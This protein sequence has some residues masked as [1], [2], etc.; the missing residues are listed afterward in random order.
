MQGQDNGAVQDSGNVERIRDILFGS[1]MRDYD[2][3]FQ[4]LDERLSREAGELRSEIQRHLETLER[5]MKSEFESVA[6]RLKAEQ[7]ERMQATE[8]VLQQLAETARGLELNISHLD[9]QTAQDVRDLRERLLEQAK[10]WSA[11]LKDKHDQM[12]GQLDREAGQIRDAMTGRE[13]L[14]EMLSEVA[15]RLKREFRVPNPT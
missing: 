14:A 1:Q 8:H 9:Q 2:S 13:A 7:A 6:Q 12:K 15:L 5:F 3:R 4:R 10:S 11:E